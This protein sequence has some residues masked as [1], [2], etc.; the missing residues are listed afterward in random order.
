MSLVELHQGDRRMNGT[1]F[2]PRPVTDRLYDI[3]GEGHRATSENM[4][5]SAPAIQSMLKT[6][7]EMGDI[8]SLVMQRPRRGTV[9]A[10][11]HLGANRISSTAYTTPSSCLRDFKGQVQGNWTPHRQIVPRHPAP[12]AQPSPFRGSIPS[13]QMRSPVRGTSYTYPR[14]HYPNTIAASQPYPSPSGY[15]SSSMLSRTSRPTTPLYQP[16]A[17]R[18]IGYR[19]S[20]VMSSNMSGLG[21]PT[22]ESPES[23]TSLPGA[24][25]SFHSSAHGRNE[26]DF[27]DMRIPGAFPDDSIRSTRL[28]QRT[29]RHLP[30]QISSNLVL[31]STPSTASPLGLP[32]GGP[33]RQFAVET[34]TSIPIFY[35][36]TEGFDDEV[37]SN[38]KVSTASLSS[39]GPRDMPMEGQ[40][41]VARTRKGVPLGR[42]FGYSTGQHPDGTP[43][44]RV[45]NFV[46]QSPEVAGPPGTSP[47]KPD[48]QNHEMSFDTT[49]RQH[50]PR[51]STLVSG[52]KTTDESS[53]YRAGVV[54][55]RRSTL[56][57]PDACNHLRVAGISHS[58]R[59][60]RP[61][62]ERWNNANPDIAHSNRTSRASLERWENANPDI[63]H[64]NRTSRPSLERWDNAN[65]D[66]AHTGIDNSYPARSKASAHDNVE[67]Y[68]ETFELES[69]EDA[70]ELEWMRA[71]L[72]SE[73]E[74]GA[75]AELNTFG[76][77]AKHHRCGRSGNV[78]MPAARSIERTETGSLQTFNVP[79]TNLTTDLDKQKDHTR[80]LAS[81]TAS[82]S[83]QTSAMVPRQDSPPLLSRASFPWLTGGTNAFDENIS[84]RPVSSSLGR[85]SSQASSSFKFRQH[86]GAAPSTSGAALD[87][88]ISPKNDDKLATPSQQ[89]RLKIFQSEAAPSTSSVELRPWNL[90]ESYPWATTSPDVRVDAPF[91]APAA[92]N[93]PYKSP[94]FKL[95]MFG[96]SMSYRKVRR[97]ED[98]SVS[99][100][101]RVSG[102]ARDNSTDVREGK[103]S[104]RFDYP[105]RSD[106][107]THVN[108]TPAA[109]GVEAKEAARSTWETPYRSSNGGAA[110]DDK[111]LP[112]LDVTPLSVDHPLEMRSVF[113]DDS[114]D[115]GRRSSIRDRISSLRA[116]LATPPPPPPPPHLAL[117]S[118][119]GSG[120]IK[121]CHTPLPLEPQSREWNQDR[122]ETTARPNS[123][124]IRFKARKAAARIRRW[125]TKR[126]KQVVRLGKRSIRVEAGGTT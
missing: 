27:D 93:Q 124:S 2:S 58:K 84:E 50:V 72:K 100:T 1:D 25:L 64:S 89:L 92:D 82:S 97:S 71:T 75:L 40:L 12:Y 14:E 116:R 126:R 57:N 108:G 125:M 47:S 15:R 20:S 39:S 5:P 44:F 31:S 23:A 103:Q 21:P 9:H 28:A 62:L 122:L 101:P 46:N 70:A 111:A 113:S 3:Q 34:E 38:A 80:P 114:S 76:L 29:L 26:S 98:L 32:I 102:V 43:R 68:V 8:S 81:S 13:D 65:P 52:A 90:D 96:T 121:G 16:V 99:A 67:N 66:I 7:T 110:K 118:L 33:S 60:S 51:P 10:E 86:E 79:S 45:R 105:G 69:T 42:G 11:D 109:V 30:S 74:S 120:T 123:N 24:S 88:S 61:S 48:A 85:A 119:E 107:K 112:S 4:I 77:N 22:R 36:Y 87:S 95:K 117:R 104:G 83:K 106:S 6:R 115:Q 35:D 18:Q 17:L 59:T 63:A 56:S 94:R 78:R 41:H 37:Y 49:P 91:I 54:A 53:G 73:Y 19:I 55:E